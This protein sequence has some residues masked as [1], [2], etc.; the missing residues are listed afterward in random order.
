M[1][2]EKSEARIYVETYGCAVNRSDAEIMKGLLVK[3]G[4]KLVDS[5]Q[6]AD[7]V[8]INTCIVKQATM[9]R[10]L[11][12]IRFFTQNF[13]PERVVVAG[14]ISKPFGKKVKE[15]NPRASLVGTEAVSRIVD[16]VRA[17]L[18]GKRVE[19]LEGEDVKLKMPRVRSNKNIAIVQIS[20][21]C[22]GACAFCATRFARGKLRSYPPEDVVEDV[23][24]AIEQGCVEIWLTSQ[25][26]GCY[27]MD[28]GTNLAELLKMITSQVRGRYMIRVGM[29]NPHFAKHIIK[30]LI[31]AYRSRKIYKFI[32]V[33]VQSGSDRV[34]RI[35]K[36]Q[37]TVQDFVD[38]VNAFRR[39]FPRVSVWTDIIVGHPGEEEDDF[40]RTVELMKRVKL[41]FINVSR[42]SSHGITEAS[43][44]VQPPSQVKK[45]R[46]RIMT[47]LMRQLS[48]ERNREW[49]G[50][51]GVVLVTD[52]DTSKKNWIAHNYAYKQVIIKDENKELKLDGKFVKVK[53]VDAGHAHLEGVIVNE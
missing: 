10:M 52:Y 43:K 47:K 19:F 27:G 12:R 35:M 28:I 44:L 23:K 37:H 32:H 33:P 2:R 42:F 7:V 18:E 14:C 20:S 30:D 3:A 6:S 1:E 25:D 40:R 26:N 22:L 5:W 53:I 4:F 11:A 36:R 9:S 38:V 41:D 48:Y 16:A 15:I 34:L 29:M 46:S 49:V 21:G 51:K 45:E 50:W 17:V 31:Q 24:Q 8:I 13:R 39:V